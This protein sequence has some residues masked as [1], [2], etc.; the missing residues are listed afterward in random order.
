VDLVTPPEDERAPGDAGHLTPEQLDDL[1]GRARAD[2]D[3]DRE[4]VN[5]P[6]D[7]ALQHHLD[8]CPACRSALGDQVE[9]GALLRRQPALAPMPAD[10]AGRLDAALAAAAA[11]RA[12]VRPAPATGASPARAEGNVLPMSSAR[13]GGLSRL[14]ESKVTKS[15]VAAAAVALI[16]AGGF[17]ALHHTNQTNQA[18]SGSS[19]ASAPGAGKAAAPDASI[20]GVPIR[21][22][23]TKYTTAN[24]QSEV[25]HQ[26]TVAPT[27]LA[28][29]SGDAAQT[30]NE[31]TTLTTPA[32]LQACLTALQAPSVRPLL[33][34]LATYNGKPVAVLVLPDNSGKR[35]LWVVSR[36]CA[37]GN[38]GTVLFANLG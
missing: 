4:E 1:A 15:L 8:R 30:G 18:S 24:I 11:G 32:G 14:A 12:A 26:L 6:G 34:D 28:A 25:G 35:Q 17:A 37:P 7:R 27:S 9:V 16:A 2:V 5:D 21:M 36:R 10:V 19:S 38:D 29:G 22:S 13:S 3:P 31:S 33:V 23:G 20:A